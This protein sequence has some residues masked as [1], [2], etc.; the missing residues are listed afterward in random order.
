MS[1][2]IKGLDVTALNDDSSVCYKDIRIF[3]D[4]SAT[5]PSGEPPY[6][7]TFEW[8][9]VPT[10]HGDLIDRGELAK[11]RHDIYVEEIDYRHRCISLENLYE[12]KTVIESEE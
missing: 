4:G 7:K 2:L 10:P 8:V 6:I 5:T 1:I 3:A 11:T 12:A 9:E